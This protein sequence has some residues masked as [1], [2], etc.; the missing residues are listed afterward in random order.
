MITLISGS[1]DTVSIVTSVVTGEDD[2]GR[3]IT[4]EIITDVKA[5]VAWNTGGGIDYNLDITI[6]KSSGSIYFNKNIDLSKISKFI[7]NGETYLQD[8]EVIDWNAPIGFKIKT[9]QVVVIRKT[10]E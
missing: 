1:N 3:F 5:L 8:S 9:G 7:I 4:E 2:F 10:E 6:A